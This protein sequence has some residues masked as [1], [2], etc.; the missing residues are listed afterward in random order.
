MNTSN[1]QT[2]SPIK[3]PTDLERSSA[4]LDTIQVVLTTPGNGNWET[5]Q[6]PRLI[7]LRIL[8]QGLGHQPYLIQ[9]IDAQAEILAELPLCFVKSR[10]FGRYL[11]S[12]PYIS[13]SGVKAQSHEAAQLVIQ[14]AVELAAELDCR[15][16]ELRHETPVEHPAL[17]KTVSEKV[18]MRLELPGTV[19]VLRSNLKAKVRNQVKKG[20]SQGFSIR[21]GREEL[22][23]DFYAVFSRNMRDLGTPV[24]GRKLFQAILRGFGDAAEFCS[25]RDGERPVASA[26]LIHGP[27]ATE[28]PSASSL[29]NVNS[30]NPNMLMYFQLLARA[31]DRGQHTFDFGRSTPD[32]PTFNFKKQWGAEPVPAHWQYHVRKGDVGEVRPNNPKYQLMIRTWQKLPLWCANLIGP[33]IVRGIP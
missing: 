25:V 10:L 15:F 29:R 26:L 27:E 2:L 3:P 20:E 16:L 30:R 4:G 13:S 5:L 12:L 21:W 32:S 8:E 11:V 7:W 33:H 31:I 18:H 17:T 22:L 23:E 9:A 6:R 14:R 24:F 28:V 19:E 1:A